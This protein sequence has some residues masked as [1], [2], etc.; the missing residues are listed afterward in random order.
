MPKQLLDA[1]VRAIPGGSIIDLH[2]EVNRDAEA[3][4]NAAFDAAIRAG[5]G[6][7]LLNFTDVGYINS[8]GIAV[9]VGLLA[10]ARQD[11]HPLITY[12]LSDHYRMI[13]DVTRLSDFMQVVADEASA[14]AA[15]SGATG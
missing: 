10:R 6:S 11:N 14:V 15:V 8:T 4:L 12:G 9:I 2:G 1:R 7:V 5:A 3:D 13:F